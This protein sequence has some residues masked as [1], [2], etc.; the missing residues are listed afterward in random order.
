MRTSKTL[1]LPLLGMLMT[2][3]LGAVP[4]PKDTPILFSDDANIYYF[5]P[6]P[7]TRESWSRARRV[8]AKAE[9]LEKGSNPRF[10]VTSLSPEVWEAR[11]LYEELYCARGEMENRIKEQLSLF[12]DRTST[13]WLRSNQVRLYFSS[14]AYLLMEALRR[15][16]LAGTEL[17]R[18]QCDTLRWKLLKI[19]AQI[20]VTVRK[21]WIS[22]AEGYAYAGLFAQVWT[23]LRALPLRC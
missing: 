13:A 14:V 9:H 15:L 22:L 19:G 1:I 17:A 6:Y 20:R 4:K 21:V 2:A 10:V 8:I 12:A 23:Q 16:G 7:M 11:A 3:A 5:P 18:A